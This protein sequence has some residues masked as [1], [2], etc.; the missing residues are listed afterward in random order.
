MTD[1]SNHR[2][3][4]KVE[5]PSHTTASTTDVS[6]ELLPGQR[7]NCPPTET[8]HHPLCYLSTRA[9]VGPADVVEDAEWLRRAARNENA[10]VRVHP[11]ARENLERLADQLSAM[12][13]SGEVE[14]LARIGREHLQAGNID[15]AL[16]AFR[17]I[18]R[19]GLNSAPETR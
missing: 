5:V 10:L 8:E 9:Q 13:V 6:K 4:G 1:V 18:E 14:R 12:G 3:D 15:D 16:T 19:Q 2:F 17:R 7:C 11:A